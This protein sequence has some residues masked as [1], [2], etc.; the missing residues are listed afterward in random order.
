MEKTKI[1]YSSPEHSKIKNFLIQV[2]EYMTGRA[3]LERKYQEILNEKGGEKNIWELF[4]EKL[5]LHPFFDQDQIR[6]SIS[7]TE[8]QR[9]RKFC[10]TN[11]GEETVRV[12]W[13]E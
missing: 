5:E 9:Q 2:I 12:T 13:F 10:E 11:V 8:S 4:T 3:R 1:T 7:Q 6:P